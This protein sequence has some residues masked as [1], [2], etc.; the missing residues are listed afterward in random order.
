MGTEGGLRFVATIVGGG[1]VGYAIVAMFRGTLYDSDEGTIDQAE[2]PVAF[3]L[4][5]FGMTVLGLFSGRSCAPCS[6]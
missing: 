2:R 5:V 3:W 6:S 1:F 4:S